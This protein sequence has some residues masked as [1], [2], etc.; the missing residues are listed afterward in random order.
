VG[1]HSGCITGHSGCIATGAFQMVGQATVVSL[2]S[3]WG[4]GR[5]VEVRA[6]APFHGAL[7]A[8]RDASAPRPSEP[9]HTAATP[10]S[11]WGQPLTRIAAQDWSVPLRVYRFRSA[12]TQLRG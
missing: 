5:S 7:L 12:L 9:E 11:S 2:D 3:G 10:R 1:R 4:E 8:C 6:P